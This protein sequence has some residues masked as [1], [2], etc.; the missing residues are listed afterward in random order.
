MLEYLKIAGKR[1]I[2][3]F[4]SLRLCVEHSCTGRV[5]R[6]PAPP[7]FLV[8]LCRLRNRI[9]VSK[10]RCL[11]S[12]TKD[13][14]PKNAVSRRGFLGGMGIGTGAVGA[15]LLER[16]AQA[17]PAAAKPELTSSYSL[18][19]VM[20]VYLLFGAAGFFAAAQML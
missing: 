10:G 6:L 1:A 5:L 20:L 12:S 19:V 9:H 13:P 14:K 7:S 18:I 15:G 4:A 17:A 2:V 8:Y 3:F 11:V 16:E